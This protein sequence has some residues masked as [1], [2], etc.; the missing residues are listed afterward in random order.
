MCCLWRS[1]GALRSLINR[2]RTLCS[3][4]EFAGLLQWLVFATAMKETAVLPPHPTQMSFYLL[5]YV[6]VRLSSVSCMYQTASC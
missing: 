3:S 1:V 6:D 4:L 5:V 2:Q